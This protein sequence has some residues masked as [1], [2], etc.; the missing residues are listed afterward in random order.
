MILDANALSGL[1]FENPEIT[2]LLATGAPHHLPVIVL[3][4][5]KAGVL[6]SQKRAEMM[7]WLDHVIAR[8]IV[9]DVVSRTAEHYASICARL[10]VNG[11]PIPINDMWIG[12]L[13]LQHNLPVVS[14]D[15]H[16]DFIDG[17]QRVTW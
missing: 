16:F 17:V 14:R 12:A 2:A 6:R 9:L 4:E 13:A 1:S 7:R 11:T 8:S 3:G 10:R 15:A 5:Y